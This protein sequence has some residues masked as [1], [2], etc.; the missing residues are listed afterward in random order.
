MANSITS[1]AEEEEEKPD[2][3][4]R[5]E[6]RHGTLLLGKRMPSLSA[7][8]EKW[9]KV[10][11]TEDGLRRH[12]MGSKSAE[13]GGSDQYSSSS[14]SSTPPSSSKEEEEEE[15]EDNNDEEEEEEEGGKD[16]ENPFSLFNNCFA[17]LFH[18]LTTDNNHEQRPPQCRLSTVSMAQNSASS[19][20]RPR[21]H[22][23]RR[24]RRRRHFCRS[25]CRFGFGR[26]CLYSLG[27]PGWVC[28]LACVCLLLM[29]SIYALFPPHEPQTSSTTEPAP[30]VQPYNSSNNNIFYSR[31]LSIVDALC[32]EW[33]HGRYAGDFCATLCNG[34]GNGTRNW[35]LADYIR[36]G[37][38]HV[39]KLRIDGRDSVL[40]MQFPYAADYDQKIDFDSVDEGK[41]AD[42][43]LD[44]VNEHLRLGWPQRHKAQLL[45]KIWPPLNAG[46]RRRALNATEKRSVWALLQQDEFINSAILQ[47]SRVTPKLLDVCGHAYRVEYLIPFRMKPYYLNLKAKILIHLMGTLKLFHEFLNEPF[48]WCDVKFDNLGLSADYPKRFVVMDSDMLYTESRLDTLLRAQRCSNDTQCGLFDC[49]SQCNMASGFCTG[50]TNDNIDVFC[51]KL[52]VQQLFGSFWSKSNRYLSACHD[53]EPINATQR[54]NSLRLTWAWTLSDV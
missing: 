20:H 14:Y 54:L 53:P 35:T 34:D 36:G 17:R 49:A 37:N 26:R 51:K 16:G 40:K 10:K 1:G 25:C 7:G 32:S 18:Y 9:R 8:G 23:S 11:Q 41:F 44:L 50:R 28:L 15:E 13:N 22:S 31:A 2:A 52:V 19:H 12:G 42:M 47:M 48:Q 4:L 38:K 29:F 39:L 5:R 30:V 24:R 43:L 46:D 3:H 45:R 27:L 21:H 33:R 6:G